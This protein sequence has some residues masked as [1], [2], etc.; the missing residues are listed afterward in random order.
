[1]AAL[2]GVIGS[3]AVSRVCQRA[4][5]PF[6]LSRR[7][8]PGRAG[9]SGT[10]RCAGPLQTLQTAGRPASVP[11]D[12]SGQ[13]VPLPSPAPH[14]PSRHGASLAHLILPPSERAHSSELKTYRA[15]STE[16][17]RHRLYA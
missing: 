8:L 11:S 12:Q 2:R 1:M 6:C 13:Y 14:H 15:S 17:P 7:H 10:A 3:A 4:V 5:S 16:F 9:R